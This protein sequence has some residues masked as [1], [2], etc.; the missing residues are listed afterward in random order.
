MGLYKHLH[1]DVII[2]VRDGDN[3]CSISVAAAVRNGGRCCFRAVLIFELDLDPD[4]G[5][6][7]REIHLEKADM[8]TF[9]GYPSCTDL[10]SWTIQALL[11]FEAAKRWAKQGARL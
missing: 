7:H 8:E 2:L 1:D 9:H 4:P 10:P 11:Y 5:A 3:V 6:L